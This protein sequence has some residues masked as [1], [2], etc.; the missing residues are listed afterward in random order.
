MEGSCIF[1][2]ARIG[3]PSAL[4]QLTDKIDGSLCFQNRGKK[5]ARI[6]IKQFEKILDVVRVRAGNGNADRKFSTEK[7][8]TQFRISSSLALDSSPK[9]A[10]SCR[11]SR[12]G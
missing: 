4:H 8:C 3:S 9:R 11:S 1:T 12:D 7:C 10:P 2:A 5:F 6:T